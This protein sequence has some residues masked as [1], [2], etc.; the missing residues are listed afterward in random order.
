MPK[1]ETLRK[2]YPNSSLSDAELVEIA[3]WVRKYLGRE[4][5]SPGNIL[6]KVLIKWEEVQR[7]NERGGS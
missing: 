3:E 5:I 7:K 1:P 4:H 2:Y 6:L